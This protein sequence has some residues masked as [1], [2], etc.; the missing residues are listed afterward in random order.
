MRS[1]C[2]LFKTMDRDIT[3]SNVSFDNF[4]QSIG[5]KLPRINGV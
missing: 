2:P 4:E 5:Q 1:L 3:L